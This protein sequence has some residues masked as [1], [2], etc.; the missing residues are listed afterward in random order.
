[1]TPPST[2]QMFLLTCADDS[3]EKRRN[4][5]GMTRRKRIRLQRL[6]M[7]EIQRL[8]LQAT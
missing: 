1:M 7:R 5:P 2:H 8:D 4:D 6:N 3:P